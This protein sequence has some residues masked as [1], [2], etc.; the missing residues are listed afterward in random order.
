MKISVLKPM[1]I[2][3]TV[4]DVISFQ[5]IPLELLQIAQL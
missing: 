3:Y 1:Y 2:C 5:I 4:K